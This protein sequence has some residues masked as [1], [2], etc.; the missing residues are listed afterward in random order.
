MLKDDTLLEHVQ[1]SEPQ[2]IHSL[3]PLK[4]AVLLGHWY[5]QYTILT[6]GG[7]ITIH[8]LQLDR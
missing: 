4:Q 1:F 8:I 6:T 7:V 3:T 5:V 2:S